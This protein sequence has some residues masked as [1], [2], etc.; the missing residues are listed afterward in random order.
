MAVF[1]MLATA[2]P[3]G[4]KATSNQLAEVTTST[5][6]NAESAA[7][8]ESAK[9][10]EPKATKGAAN[11]FGIPQVAAINELV[12]KSW[13][14]HKL[15]PSP[16]ATDGQWCRRVYLDTIGRIP[17]VD[18]LQKFLGDHSAN[19]K[20]N[21]VNRLLGDEYVE[22]YAR[23]WSNI[24]TT[25]LIGRSAGTKA[26]D[27]IPVDREAMAQWLRRSFENNKPYSTMVKELVSATGDIKSDDGEN[28]D[29]NAAAN[30]LSGKMDADG[31][32][33]TA[34]TAQI[35]LGLSVQC[36]QCH[37]HPFNDWKQNQFWEMNAFFRQTKVIKTMAKKKKVEDAKLVDVNFR[38][39]GS[40]PQ[41][42]ELY[43]EQRNG[44]MRV[45]YPVFVDGTE[46]SRSGYVKDINRRDELAK[47]IVASPYMSREIVNRMWGH[48]MGYGFTKPVDDMGPHNPPSNPELLDRLAAD[49]GVHQYANDGYDL[50]QLMRWIVLSEPY[51]LSSRIIPANKNDDPNLGEKPQFSH[52]YL[53]QMSAE[54]LYQ[55]LLTA[56]SAD[57]TRGNS[58]EQEK[59][60]QEWLKQ[61]VINFGTDDGGETT[62]FN[63]SIPQTLMMFNGTLMKGATAA[64]K[65]SVLDLVANNPRY[66][67]ADKINYLYLAGLA[68]KPNHLELELANE[69][70]SD[71]RANVVAALQD[72]WWAV[73]NSNEFILNH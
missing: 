43:Y 73:L 65:G 4:S 37:N 18:E 67:P 69:L 17:R 59:A 42:A 2:A 24:W 63:G 51:S 38:G 52:F 20:L 25:I 48:F 57:K 68:R 36:T 62:T 41:N 3:P 47:M 71:R 12:H 66:S 11:S 46:I 44:I 33:A 22:D 61:F 54:E 49:F 31:I 70:L 23:N 58:E 72:V 27:K 6:T 34:K 14:D 29:Y 10:A 15:T 1:S 39:E 30:F 7:P 26:D 8:S 16:L 35:F 50:K 28:K 56:T 40:D 64:E 45:A 32:Q 13:T 55:S 5:E 60:K 53:R 19:R 9:P 21:L